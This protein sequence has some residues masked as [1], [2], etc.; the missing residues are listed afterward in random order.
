MQID[1]R[2]SA[3]ERSQEHMY[4]GDSFLRIIG[5]TARLA[6]RL[7]WRK[8]MSLAVLFI[9]TPLITGDIEYVALNLLGLGVAALLIRRVTMS[10]TKAQAAAFRQATTATTSTITTRRTR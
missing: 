2:I 5:I 1:A 3:N 7:P 10:R 8:E 9:G 4:I 6:G